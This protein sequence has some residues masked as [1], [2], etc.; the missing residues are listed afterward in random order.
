MAAPVASSVRRASPESF[1]GWA[2]EKRCEDVVDTQRLV[3]DRAS[4]DPKVFRKAKNRVAGMRREWAYFIRLRT[5]RFDVGLDLQGHSKT[6]LCLRLAK[7]TKRFAIRA[8]DVF[9][10]SLNPI[11]S[12]KEGQHTVERNLEALRLATGLD[13]DPTPIMPEHSLEKEEMLSKLGKD[14]RIATISVSAGAQ[15]KEYPLDRWSVVAQELL[16]QGYTVAFLG[17]PTDKAP[18]TPN[19]FD[20]VGKL[21]LAQSMAAVAVSSIHLAADTGTG[22]MAAAYGV[23]VVSIFGPTDPNL[24]RPYIEKGIV[25]CKGDATENV[26]TDEVIQ[27]AITLND[28]YGDQVSH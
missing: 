3:D 24:Y 25:L 2:V 9:A 12:I 14:R 20:F 13:T 17:G 22:H 19:A 28:R 5:L 1:I 15:I 4:Y 16:K 23:P 6:A 7:P 11:L 26:S 21:S 10:R 8:T 27:A 18:G